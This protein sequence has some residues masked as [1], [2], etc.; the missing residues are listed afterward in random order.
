MSNAPPAPIKINALAPAVWQRV[1]DLFDEVI[2]LDERDRVAFVKKVWATE[3]AVASELVALLMSAAQLEKKPAVAQAPFDAVLGQA[4]DS[5]KA[6]AANASNAAYS[7]GQKF[8]AWTLESRLGMGGMGEVWRA[9]RSD[10]LYKAS[11]AL[12]LLRSDMPSEK[13]SARFRRERVVLARLNHP[14]IARLLDAGVE[15]GQA[16]IVLELVEGIQLLDYVTQR[17][18]KLS[19]RIRLL[20]DIARAVEHAHNQ[21]VLHRDLKP[22]NVLVTAS[23]DVKL[24]DFGIAG[25]LD[26]SNDEPMTKLTQL[27]GRGMT[28][29]YA[30]P[31]QIAGDA[32]TATSD[33]Y[34][35]GVL[36]FHLCT[37]NRPF[38]GNTTRATLEYAMVNSEPPLASAHIVAHSKTPAASDQIAAPLDADRLD[39]ELDA[40]IQRAMRR[41][42]S[43]RYPSAAEFAN[44]LDAWM[45]PYQKTNVDYDDTPDEDTRPWI[46]KHWNT[47]ALIGASTL[48]I[49]TVLGLSLWQRNVAINNA[50]IAMRQ[51]DRVMAQLP[52]G[53]ATMSADSDSVIE[54]KLQHIALL[55]HSERP[56]G[57]LRAIDELTPSIISRYGRTSVN[58]GKFLLLRA[59]ALHAMNRHDDARAAETD[60]TKLGVKR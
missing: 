31:E 57:A 41:A 46:R 6:N 22:T 33:V 20:R 59:D 49:I 56:S 52:M 23:G 55:L 47:A 48:A 54:I 28:P 13:L 36:L 35:L 51:L 17:A 9:K 8:G 10:G 45:S 60:A 37:G 19:D 38:A 1:S 29:E 21:R 50:D 27:T 44:A 30:S 43:D 16:F 4:F 24:L 18:P 7:E 39:G 15:N 32:T 25:V 26:D 40:I 2:E 12:K 5:A 58:Y 11:A 42:P 34:S 53:S 14:N 3:P